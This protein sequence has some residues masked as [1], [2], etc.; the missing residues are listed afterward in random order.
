MRP[1]I[2]LNMGDKMTFLE[3]DGRAV[4][5]ATLLS[6]GMDSATLAYYL[7]PVPQVA[8]TVDYG[9]R[10]AREMSSAVNICRQLS[11]KHV[12]LKTSGIRGG[13]LM[14]DSL[15]LSGTDTVVPG[16][17]GILLSLAVNVAIQ[18]DC[19]RIAIGCNANDHETYADC[20]K[21]YLQTIGKSIAMTTGLRLCFPFVSK[22]K[23]DI[24]KLGN[25]L[26]VPFSDTWSCYYGGELPCGKCGACIEVENSL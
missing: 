24:R 10:H 4:K 26:E 18:N 11:I 19:C 12:T 21:E 6:G 20:R 14:G 23:A 17:N 5:Y 13:S 9:Q 1:A 15:S 2:T 22:S 7:C 16:R 3:E 8:I 25:S